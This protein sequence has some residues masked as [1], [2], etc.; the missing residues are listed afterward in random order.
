M[1][2]EVRFPKFGMSTVEVEVSQV[3]V[4]VGD[5]VA[6]GD[7]LVE[8][9]TDKV[10]VNMEAEVGGVIVELK[11]RAGSEYEVGDLVCLIDD[12]AS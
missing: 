2:T 9:E 3:F 12:S 5:R 6:I 7:P 11:V 10:T 1:A 8:V 4:S